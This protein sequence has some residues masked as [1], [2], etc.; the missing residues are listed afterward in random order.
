MGLF[1]WWKGEIWPY[2]ALFVL[3]F[4]LLGI[5]ILRRTSSTAAFIPYIFEKYNYMKYGS[6]NVILTHELPIFFQ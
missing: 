5:D 4:A 2:K 1:S 3:F 6:T